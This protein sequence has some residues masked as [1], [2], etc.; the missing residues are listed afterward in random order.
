[1]SFPK[2]GRVTTSLK[3]AIERSRAQRLAIEE[4]VPGRNRA[5]RRQAW[6]DLAGK[7]RRSEIAYQMAEFVK[8]AEKKAQKAA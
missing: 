4:N 7:L 3:R 6:F 1:M 5:E 2:A 8:Q